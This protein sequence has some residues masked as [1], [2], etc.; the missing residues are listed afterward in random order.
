MKILKRYKTPLLIFY[1]GLIL[2]HFI[3]KDSIY[4]LSVLFYASPL[5]LIIIYGFFLSYLHRKIKSRLSLIIVIQIT[6]L[7]TWFNNNYFTNN[8]K[9]SEQDTSIA[10]WNLAKKK[11]FPYKIISE[12]IK[13]RK[14]NVLMFVEDKSSIPTTA[15]KKYTYKR[16]PD[17]ISILFKGKLIET[18]SYYK[19]QSYH[20]NTVSIKHNNSITSYL[21]ADI[22]ASPFTN[23]TEALEK[24][25]NVAKAKDIDF[26]VGDF[27]T[28]FE[29][30]H[31]E[32]FNNH[33][34]SFRLKSN[35][36]TSTWYYGFPL[37]ELDQIWINKKYKALLLEKNQHLNSDHKILIGSFN[38]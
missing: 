20:F 29:S 34:N 21:I 6:L 2:I 14:P 16:L 22:Y 26:I 13:N 17:N 8:H 18:K 36:F 28:P 9:I 30:I 25:I 10:F 32:K 31:F 38:P 23:K 27:N 37:L 3:I 15:F 35:G 11:S 12:T 1:I 5:I 4:P 33:Y 7:L 19:E 24:I